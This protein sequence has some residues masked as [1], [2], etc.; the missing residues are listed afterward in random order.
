M[1]SLSPGIYNPIVYLTTYVDDQT[2]ER[3]K[4]TEP[5]GYLLKPLEERELRTTIEIALYKHNF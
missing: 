5:F 1:R 2:V 4:V 3:A